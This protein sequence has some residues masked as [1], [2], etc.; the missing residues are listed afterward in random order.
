[1]YLQRHGLGEFRATNHEDTTASSFQRKN[2]QLYLSLSLDS[3]TF[4]ENTKKQAIE[5]S[6]YTPKFTNKA[7]SNRILD[8]HI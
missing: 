5:K 8:Y 3:L 7:I 1:M 6:L 4:S 2:Q